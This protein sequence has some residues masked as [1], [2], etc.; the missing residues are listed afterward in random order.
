MKV[1]LVSQMVTSGAIP[2]SA[3]RVAVANAEAMAKIH[4]ISISYAITAAIDLYSKLFTD[5]EIEELNEMYKSPVM[6]KVRGTSSLMV[7]SIVKHLAA[8][9]DI[10]DQE[11]DEVLQGQKTIQ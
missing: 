6:K 7:E 5:E 11:I 1:A 8:N 3:M 9:E 2:N 10:I 4:L